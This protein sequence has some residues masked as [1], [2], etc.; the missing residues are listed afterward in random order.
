MSG[1]VEAPQESFASEF[2]GWWLQSDSYGLGQYDSLELQ[3]GDDL[4]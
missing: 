3:A 2:C 4:S 1:C